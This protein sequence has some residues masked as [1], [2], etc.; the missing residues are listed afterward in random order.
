MCV[1]L[2]Q[3]SPKSPHTRS[4]LTTYTTERRI[5]VVSDEALCLVSTIKIIMLNMDRYWRQVECGVCITGLKHRLKGFV[6]VSC[7]F[8]LDPLEGLL[9]D[10]F[11]GVGLSPGVY[12][13][14]L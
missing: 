5:K 11:V 12:I 7:Y 9:E 10:L 4:L 3:S 14:F 8:I 2:H 6:N 13:C 1:L